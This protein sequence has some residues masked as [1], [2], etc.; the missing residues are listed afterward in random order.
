MQAVQQVVRAQH[1]PHAADASEQE[2]IVVCRRVFCGDEVTDLLRGQGAFQG[3]KDSGVTLGRLHLEH[4]LEELTPT[5]VRQDDIKEV[6]MQNTEF[7]VMARQAAFH[8]LD[9]LADPQLVPGRIVEDVAGDLVADALAGQKGRAGDPGQN[10]VQPVN[11]GRAHSVTSR[12]RS[13]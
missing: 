7:C 1:G 10:L 11:E 12:Q 8:H 5:Q 4:F 9:V 6:E 13:T 3:P 2:Q